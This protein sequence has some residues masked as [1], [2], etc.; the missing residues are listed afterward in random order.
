MTVPSTADNIDVTQD[1]WKDGPKIASLVQALP[2][3]G[4]DQLHSQYQLLQSLSPCL[5]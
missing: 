5:S 4:P 3:L 1:S 2:I